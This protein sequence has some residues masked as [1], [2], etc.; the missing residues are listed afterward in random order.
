[1]IIRKLKIFSQNV[2]KNSFITSSILESYTQFDVILIQEPPWSEIQKIL[3]AYNC[4]G[5]PLIGSC[6]HPNWI[7]FSRIPQDNN[8]FPRV[9]SYVNNRLSSL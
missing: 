1:M 3:S 6:H 5:K 2:R 7:A 9:I 8:D 4:E